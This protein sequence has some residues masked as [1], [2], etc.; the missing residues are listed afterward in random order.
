MG[1]K[2]IHYGNSVVAEER[3][4]I[5]SIDAATV[6][7]ACARHWAL[8][9]AHLWDAPPK[10]LEY[11]ETGNNELRRA[12]KSAA[13]GVI[14]AS[15]GSKDNAMFM[16][17]TAAYATFAAAA[18]PRQVAH[19]AH[20]IALGAAVNAMMA[21]GEKAVSDLSGSVSQFDMEQPRTYVAAWG[22]ARA[23]QEQ[24]IVEAV[25]KAHEGSKE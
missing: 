14:L 17:R 22:A 6:L 9:V 12:A 1:G 5:W 11:L 4:I 18:T 7:S 10:A 24:Y 20:K 21:I 15:S 13:R 2:A 3:T 16:A 19:E 23:R 25:M 8:E